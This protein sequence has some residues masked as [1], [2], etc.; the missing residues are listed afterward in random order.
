[1]NHKQETDADTMRPEYDFD[2]S[3]AEWGKFAGKPQGNGPQVIL[4]EPDIAEVFRDSASVNEALRHLIEV[5]RKAVKAGSK[6][7]KGNTKTT[8]HAQKE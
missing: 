3:N 1:M 2:Y 5:S 8:A 4:L 6:R 7:K